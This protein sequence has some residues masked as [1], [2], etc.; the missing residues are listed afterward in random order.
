[1]RYIST[2][3]LTSYIAQRV[4]SVGLSLIIAGLSYI[5]T[6]VQAATYTDG[7]YATL[8]S[9]CA[10][11]SSGICASRR[12]PGV[13][14]THNDSSGG[15]YLYS[16]DE[17]GQDMGVFSYQAGSEDVE[18]IAAVTI[19]GVH[20][21]VLGNIG[22]HAQVGSLRRV[23]IIKEPQADLST[24]HTFHYIP[25][26]DV[27]TIK[28][29]WPSS[30]AATTNSEA[31]AVS[32][33]GEIFI[34]TKEGGN[35]ARV[36]VLR[37]KI[38]TG[39]ASDSFRLAFTLSSSRFNQVTGMDISPDGR[40]MVLVNYAMHAVSEFTL[41][42]GETSFSHSSPSSWIRTDYASIPAV[43]PEGI[44]YSLDGTKIFAT[45]E[46]GGNS[47][48]SIGTIGDGYVFKGGGQVP[49]FMRTRNNGTPPPINQAPVAQAQNV[50]TTQG[51]SK[52]VVLSATDADGD[53]LTYSVVSEPAHGAL[54]G[55][56]PN[57][58]YKPTA[59]YSG[60]DSV[61]FQAND[62]TVSSN[63]ATISITITADP[64]VTT[65]ALTVNSG[66]GDG[67]YTAGTVVTITA[68][69]APTGQ[70]FNAWS[71]NVTGIAHINAASTTLT[72]PAGAA[73]IT[74]TY[75]TIAPPPVA[76]VYE[77]E[78]ATV[79]GA[80]IF[81]T[82]VDFT[83]NSND[84][85][86]WTV[87]AARAG[88]YILG[89]RYAN[90]SS[91]RPLKLTV[92]GVVIA[93]KFAFPGTGNMSIYDTINTTVTLRAGANKVRVTAIGSSG[94]NFDSLTVSPAPTGIAMIDT[95]N[96]LGSYIYIKK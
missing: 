65:Y 83:N 70:I 6:S 51:I 60:S 39:D 95:E 44:C 4:N 96:I 31:L 2:I 26:E 55:T 63:I 34:A 33:A 57:L 11:E 47:R 61:T 36:F 28:F 19:G 93:E 64:V 53:A 17:H 56:A 48:P 46:V 82:F 85:I 62:G 52:S 15:S 69:A 92:N 3:S 87:N 10:A 18:D 88:D 42:S 1:M 75:Q 22:N 86:E 77:A 89:F 67:I 21:I 90:S 74:A 9:A 29:N 49:L 68:D 43:Q 59:G 23:Y 71:G 5:P 37:T 41:P 14:W 30:I 91:N 35:R 54:S 12:N 38:L 80:K 45:S 25:R 78:K 16:F 94:P 58:V 8:E 79:V 50:S 72:M 7:R 24:R 84:Y 40:S 76:V 27:T 13:Y 81:A 73:T 32:P 20:Y 66:G